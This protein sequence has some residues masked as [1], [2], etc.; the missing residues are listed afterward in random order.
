MNHNNLGLIPYSIFLLLSVFINIPFLMRDITNWW[1]LITL[2]F[3]L[4]HYQVF[5]LALIPIVGYISSFILIV[6]TRLSKY[7]LLSTASLCGRLFWNN[8][9]GLAYDRLRRI[10][11]KNVATELMLTTLSIKSCC[12]ESLDSYKVYST[13]DIQK[14]IC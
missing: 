10:G 9:T 8:E 3:L 12:F 13:S 2:R 4:F 5:L 1:L 7:I 11:L 6:L 14:A